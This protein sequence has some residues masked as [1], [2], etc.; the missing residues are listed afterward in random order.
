MDAISKR[1]EEFL[2]KGYIL[3][4]EIC[5][6]CSNI[7]IR[8]PKTNILL[9]PSCGYREEKEHVL[10]DIE[11]KILGLLKGSKNSKEI[12]YLLKSLYI[13]TKIKNRKHK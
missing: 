6:N 3:T 4:D 9:C 8:D 1:Y 7:L 12:Y 10:R 5:P 13:I 2:K 11:S